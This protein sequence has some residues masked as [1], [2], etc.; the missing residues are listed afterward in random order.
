MN[1][2]SGTFAQSGRVEDPIRRNVF[3]RKYGQEFEN[4]NKRRVKRIDEKMKYESYFTLYV[5]RYNII[6]ILEKTPENPEPVKILCTIIMNN[7]VY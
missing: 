3:Q 5:H 2:H 7:D 6:Q 4:P 1:H